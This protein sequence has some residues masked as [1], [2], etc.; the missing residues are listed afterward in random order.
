[1]RWSGVAAAE[2]C[3]V[4]QGYSNAAVRD[5]KDRSSRVLPKFLMLASVAFCLGNAPVA[6]LAEGTL[7]GIVKAAKAARQCGLK[8][9]RI[10]IHEEI[11]MIFDYRGELW[12]NQRKSDLLCKMDRKE[13]QAFGYF[14]GRPDTYYR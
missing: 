4:D 1:M 3:T 14:L 9:M 5:G 7:D 10:Q 2:R 6:P 11:T 8:E 12:R 13:C